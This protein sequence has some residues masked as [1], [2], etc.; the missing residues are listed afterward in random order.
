MS[1]LSR[2]KT[3]WPQEDR[4]DIA[5][6][7]ILFLISPFMSFLYSLRTIN[8][9]SSFIVG[10]LFC[11]CFGMAFTV[12]NVREE[13]SIDGISYRIKFENYLN[14][15][16]LDY[17]SG[18]EDFLS[19]QGSTKDY[20]FDTIAFYV[21]RI[22]DNYHV[23]FMAFA[24]IF[25]FFMYKSLRILTED[26]SFQCGLV[27]I[28][29][30]AMFCW[31]SIFN[32]NGV[33]FWTAAWVGTY[34]ILQCFY[35]GKWQYLAL[36]LI[37]PF[38][39]GSFWFFLIVAL[40]ALLLGRFRKVWVS[41]FFISMFVSNVAVD[42]FDVTSDYIPSFLEGTIAYYTDDFYMQD[43]HQRSLIVTLFDIAYKAY[44]NILIVLLIIS[45]KSQI[46]KVDKKF[47]GF[48]LVYMTIVN[49]FGLIPSLGNRFL[50][51]AMPFIAL[52]WLRVYKMQVR[53]VWILLFPAC[54][55]LQIYQLIKYQYLAVLDWSFYF[56]SPFMM[57]FDYL[58]V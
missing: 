19:F 47:F 31:N 2:E 53:N 21:S 46:N 37:T 42:I 40:V 56:S 12:G 49:F 10:F 14:D 22:T 55:L 38:I 7:F 13:G 23:M 24:I 1:Y 34:A 48:L 4:T 17:Y 8:R 18:L 5:I 15:S 58:V 16:G 20:Y 45:D 43:V 26:D 44:L 35:K 3:I 27:G 9:K 30:V 33:R 25:A 28:L 57:I 6:K 50:V 39:H 54:F 52:M 11:I 36:A 41:L 29:L 51:V 32:I